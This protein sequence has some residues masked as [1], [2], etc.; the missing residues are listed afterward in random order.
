MKL[1]ICHVSNGNTTWHDEMLQ[2]WM[3]AFLTILLWLYFMWTLPF[4]DRSCQTWDS[5]ISISCALSPCHTDLLSWLLKRLVVFFRS[6]LNDLTHIKILM[7][8]P[9]S[10]ANSAIESCIPQPGSKQLR[11]KNFVHLAACQKKVIKHHSLLGFSQ[12]IWSSAV[13]KEYTQ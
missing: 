7:S 4:P 3:L 5:T 11:Q 2:V 6:V 13:F 8:L 10:S 1:V 9:M 12:L